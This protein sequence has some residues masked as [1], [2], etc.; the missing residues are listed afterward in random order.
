MLSEAAELAA[1]AGDWELAQTALDELCLHFRVEPLVIRE[2]MV[3]AA[4]AGIKSFDEASLLLVKFSEL[5]AAAEKANDYA[6]AVKAMQSAAAAFKKPVFKPLRDQALQDGKRFAEYQAAY[7][8]AVSASEK[9]IED[10]QD[11]AANLTWGRFLCF[12]KGDWERGL[13][14]LAQAGDKTWQPLAERELHKP[15]RSSELIE[16][17]DDW[18]RAGEKEKDPI[19]FYTGDRADAAWQAAWQAATKLETPQLAQQLDQRF[20]R[21]FGKSVLVT[22]GDPEGV[23]LP[24]TE[25]L[26]PRDEFTIEFWVSTVAT[27]GVL[28]S[29]LHTMPDISIQLGLR[30]GCLSPQSAKANT[31]GGTTIKDSINDGRWHHVALVRQKGILSVYQDGERKGQMGLIEQYSSVSPWKLGC[32]KYGGPPCAARFA[33]IRLSGNV[34]YS[35]PF[36]PKKQL[37]K[38]TVT[39]YLR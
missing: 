13:P 15:Q 6:M 1:Q 20:T 18:F 14:L 16:L 8:A 25:G 17:G 7:E 3:S 4:A 34:R 32:A 36:T 35:E 12:Y 29:K 23:T 38:D 31:W 11:S 5:A 19:R 22:T 2:Q 10:P 28:I 37:T 39:L 27:Q 26:D 9:L 33:R 24:G 30:E 21:L